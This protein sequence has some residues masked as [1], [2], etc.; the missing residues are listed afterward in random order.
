MHS[1]NGIQSVSLRL[2]TGIVIFIGFTIINYFTLFKDFQR[3]LELKT[4]HVTTQTTKITEMIDVVLYSHPINH[5]RSFLNEKRPDSYEYIPCLIVSVQEVPYNI[6]ACKKEGFVNDI[7][8]RS[9]AQQWLNKTVPLTKGFNVYINTQK[10]QAYLEAV[11][12]V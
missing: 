10:T 6:K 11:F 4:Y 8:D 9:K 5:K 2:F 1:E 7:G 12:I 3:E